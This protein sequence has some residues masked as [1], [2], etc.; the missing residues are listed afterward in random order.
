MYHEDPTYYGHEIRLHPSTFKLWCPDY[1]LQDDTIDGLKRQIKAQQVKRESRP[2]VPVLFESRHSDK[3][4]KGMA[5]GVPTRDGGNYVW[6]TYEYGGERKR[7]QEYHG[8]VYLDNANN[9]KLLKDIDSKKKEISRLEREVNKLENK[10]EVI[11]LVEP[12]D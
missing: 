6:V 7:E 2:A 1:D 9:R 11:K 4:V 12:E 3:L 5:T 10:L 8:S